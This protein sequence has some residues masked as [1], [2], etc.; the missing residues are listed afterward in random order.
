MDNKKTACGKPPAAAPGRNAPPEPAS[1]GSASP[2]ADVAGSSIAASTL[3]AAVPA[4]SPSPPPPPVGTA[5]QVAVTSELVQSYRVAN[6]FSAGQDMVPAQDDNGTWCVLSLDGAG[7]LL[8]FGL[9][10]PDQ[11]ASETLETQILGTPAF[12]CLAAARRDTLITHPGGN[13][14]AVASTVVA[15]TTDNRIVYFQLQGRGSITAPL[16]LPVIPMQAATDTCAVHD[17]KVGLGVG[18]RPFLVALCHVV[19]V[20]ANNPA[21]RFFLFDGS[22]WMP[23][24]GDVQAVRDWQPLLVQRLNVPDAPGIYVSGTSNDGRTGVWAWAQDTALASYAPFIAGDYSALACAAPDAN[25][26]VVPG[27]FALSPAD[28]G[29]CWIG[30]QPWLPDAQTALQKALPVPES[31]SSLQGGTQPPALAFSA[32]KVVGFDRGLQM[33]VLRADHHVYTLSGMPGQEPWRESMW[34]T[35]HFDTPAAR[36]LPVTG[37]GNGA[38]LLF[39]DPMHQ[40]HRA[41]YGPTGGWLFD[42]FSRLGGGV[43]ELPAY[44]LQ[45]AFFDVDDTPAPHTPVTVFADRALTLEING[46]L[47]ALDASTPWVGRSGPDGKLQIAL[48]TQALEAPVLSLWAPFMPAQDRLLVHAAGAVHARLAALTLQQVTDATMVDAHGTNPVKLVQGDTNVENAGPVTQAV[49]KIMLGSLAH[50]PAPSAH[51]PP[52]LHRLNDPSLTS[53]QVAGETRRFGRSDPS[54]ATPWQLDFSGGAPA[55]STLS[56]PARRAPAPTAPAMGLGDLLD[57]ISAGLARLQR[58]TVG[59]LAAGWAEVRYALGSVEYVLHHPVQAFED[60]FHM[61]RAAW[62]SIGVKAEHLY[63]WLGWIFD[64]DD[65]RRSREAIEYL[66]EQ[67]RLLCMN[68]ADTAE[69]RARAS[70][71]DMKSR[72]DV[73]FDTFRSTVLGAQPTTGALRQRAGTPSAGLERAMHRSTA[74][75]PFHKGLQ[76][77][78]TNMAVA[79]GG[80]WQGLQT[81]VDA[82]IDALRVHLENMS[83]QLSAQPS[84][85]AASGV[86][87]GL[88]AAMK[89]ATQAPLQWLLSHIFDAV[90]ALVDSA[91]DLA[92]Q[93]VHLAFAALKKLMDLM[94]QLLTTPLQIPYVSA[95]FLRVAGAPLTVLSLVSITLAVPVTVLYKLHASNGA[96][97]AAQNALAPF[98]TD[99]SLAQAKLQFDYHTSLRGLGLEP[100]LP[101][102][103]HNRSLEGFKRFC[104][105]LNVAAATV[106]VVLDPV[107]DFVPP[108]E[109]HIPGPAKK[110]L[111]GPYVGILSMAAIV[112]SWVTWGATTPWLDGQGTPPGIHGADQVAGIVWIYGGITGPITDTVLAATS[113]M[114]GG[115]AAARGARNRSDA[116]VIYTFVQGTVALGLH[117]WWSVEDA[118][119]HPG[120]VVEG[121]FGNLTVMA[122]LLRLTRIV[123]AQPVVLGVLAAIDVVGDFIALVSL[124]VETGKEPAEPPAQAPPS[125]G[126]GGTT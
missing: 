105:W 20:G 103:P 7:Q 111:V 119:H 16:E 121:I 57:D 41:R 73:Q 97:Q 79:G 101:P 96:G 33:L 29:I 40:L 25:G 28:R 27:L 123:E 107:L 84:F 51:A 19:Q 15:C 32:A 68:L 75:S 64:W 95:L 81:P 62:H 98:P 11:P 83:A 126:P 86:I 12:K 69:S 124:G 45:A 114:A 112:H 53:Y 67:T 39:V 17:I 49:Q 43:D 47:R 14:S 30:Q 42:D 76:H 88:A 66:V 87:D 72:F 65:I 36:L 44:Q 91:L 117:G 10:G 1:A 108:E 22:Q 92:D 24:T 70:I 109:A 71:A 31:A 48:P 115:A 26:A 8:S 99:A 85:A 122:K 58:I 46:H 89:D 5:S 90:K 80:N 82:T 125:E 9:P 94:H 50:W 59:V 93:L 60:A 61:A 34:R 113:A 55:F 56:V 116:G 100:P 63:R 106:Y 74:L 104:D 6:T 2:P 13:P 118:G 35:G 3:I 37:S 120:S 78:S 23:F 18:G 110:L 38:Q 102:G 54:D 52:V 21:L 4:P 77:H